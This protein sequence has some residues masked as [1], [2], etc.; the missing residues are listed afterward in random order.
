METETTRDGRVFRKLE[1]ASVWV[2]I[3][4]GNAQVFGDPRD[5]EPPEW[6]GDGP[7]AGSDEDDIRAHNCDAAGCSSVSHNIVLGTIAGRG[8]GGGE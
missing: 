5:V 6:N 4:T 3:E 2:C 7:P 1:H 8:T